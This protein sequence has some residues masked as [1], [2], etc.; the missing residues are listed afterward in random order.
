MNIVD[1]P[2]SRSGTV[3]RY[4][5]VGSANC[6]PARKIIIST[7]CASSHYARA[8]CCPHLT[9][10]AVS[11][12]M[13]MSMRAVGDGR[14]QCESSEILERVEKVDKAFIF[15]LPDTVNLKHYAKK[16]GTESTYESRR[17]RDEAIAK[18]CKS[19]EPTYAKNVSDKDAT[20]ENNVSTD[21]NLR[22]KRKPDESTY[23]NNVTYAKN[24]SNGTPTY[25]NNV[26]SDETYAKNVNNGE[27]G[28]HYMGGVKDLDTKELKTPLLVP[29]LTE[30]DEQSANDILDLM[31][32]NGEEILDK[33]TTDETRGHIK[34]ALDKALADIL[35]LFSEFESTDVLFCVNDMVEYRTIYAP[36]RLK[37][38]NSESMSFIRAKLDGYATQRKINTDRGKEH[39]KSKGSVDE[40]V[41]LEWIE[42]EV[43][44]KMM[45]GIIY[46][47]G[48]PVAKMRDKKPDEKDSLRE[49]LMEKHGAAHLDYHSIYEWK[50]DDG[51]EPAIDRIP[52]PSLARGTV[53]WQHNVTGRRAER[54]DNDWRGGVICQ[55]AKIECKL[56]IEAKMLQDSI[57]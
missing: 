33:P 24:V 47:N 4:L 25:E 40:A 57:R 37:V 50:F 5:Y 31:I 28:G 54:H 36:S 38:S 44:S 30:S 48:V 18:S 42:F 21:E 49:H 35:H 10:K 20:Y 17:M 3:M 32:L 56:V 23:E 8:T 43:E 1:M 41:V 15:K 46:E 12:D 2:R 11:K 34:R 45:D 39:R 9:D 55:R 26:K 6:R 53:V 22:K 51:A 29:P 19:D 27:R 13:D 7:T 52:R 14:R 16:V